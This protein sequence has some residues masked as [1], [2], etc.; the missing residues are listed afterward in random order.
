MGA[1][2]AVLAALN[3]ATWSR[4]KRAAGRPIDHADVEALLA[5]AEEP[6]A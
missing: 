3:A 5:I 2:E 6:E 4:L 1:I